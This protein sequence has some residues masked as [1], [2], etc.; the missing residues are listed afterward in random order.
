MPLELL[1]ILFAGL[2]F[3]SFITCASYRLP[4]EI[5]VVKKP[6]YCPSCNA[7]LTF[8]DLWPV[9]S[10]MTSGGKCRHC[11]AKISA[12]YPLIEII[13][14][15]IFALIYAYYGLSVQGAL[16]CLFAVALLIMV[17]ADLEHYI[18]PDQIH[19][20]LL[21]LGIFYHYVIGTDPMEVGIGFLIGMAIGLALHHGYRWLRKKE[22]LGYGDVKFFAVAGLWLTPLPIVPFL[23]L[24]GVLGVCFGL[25]WRLM[26]K[27]AIFPFGPAL[28][29]ALFLCVTFQKLTNLFWNIGIII[30]NTF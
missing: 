14:A 28:A 25:L 12:R 7:K 3:G 27:G 1:F 2:C 11:K 21:P 18:I 23:F 13:T 8:K 24:S 20:F 4:L 29:A 10:W 30:N 16:L 15:T 6:S 17:V 22:G 26:G 9:L 5:D 19:L